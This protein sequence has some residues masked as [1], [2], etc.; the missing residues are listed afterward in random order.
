MGSVSSLQCTQLVVLYGK[1]VCN[2][3][4]RGP[5]VKLGVLQYLV[6]R[7]T[8]RWFFKLWNKDKECCQY[9]A[10]IKHLWGERKRETEKTEMPVL[11][12]VSEFKFQ[13]FSIESF[14]LLSK[15]FSQ[16]RVPYRRPWHSN[17]VHFHPSRTLQLY[18]CR[19]KK[20]IQLSF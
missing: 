3:F 15:D 20:Y 13:N 10:V 4:Y 5:K 14:L 12:S 6:H 11:M 9:S 7:H 18:C 17:N 1:V 19:A 16:T 2:T 8:E